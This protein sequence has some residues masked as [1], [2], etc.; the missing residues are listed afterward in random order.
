LKGT[1]FSLK[2]KALLSA[3]LI[4]SACFLLQ[5]QIAGGE[6]VSTITS[7]TTK[8]QQITVPIYSQSPTATTTLSETGTSTLF[9]LTTFTVQAVQPHT[10]W[11]YDFYYNASAGDRL[12][13]E[14]T[15]SYVINFYIM[16]DSDLAQF[17]YCGGKHPS[18]LAVQMTKSYSLDWRAPKDETLHFVFENYAQGSDLASNRIV[19]FA[20]HKFGALPYASTFYTTVYIPSTHA[21]TVTT[22]SLYYSTQPSPLSGITAGGNSWAT[23][24]IIVV[25]LAAIVLAFL[26]RRRRKPVEPRPSTPK[27]EEPTQKLFCINCGAELRPKSKFCD[28]CGTAQS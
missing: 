28:K 8:T 14:W 13:G 16:S 18:Y 5:I 27:V 17:K 3:L 26:V 15:S 20:L 23:A 6:S 9:S 7:L 4:M 22:S 11:Y 12:Q 24:I 19:T 10:C 21:T 2:A 25:V 1:F